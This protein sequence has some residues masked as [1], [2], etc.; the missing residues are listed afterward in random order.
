MVKGCLKERKAL[1]PLLKNWTQPIDIIIFAQAFT[2]E[3]DPPLESKQ[4]I[5][6]DKIF[7]QMQEFYNTL[8]G[9]AKEVVFVPTV[10]FYGGLAAFNSI[11]H[12]KMMLEQSLDVFRVP[13]KVGFKNMGFNFKL[14]FFILKIL[15]L[16]F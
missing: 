7:Q 6:N 9:I 15:N 13:I 2:P 3:K 8:N 5:E 4:R 11:Y 16:L 12:R 10:H 1:I 14:F